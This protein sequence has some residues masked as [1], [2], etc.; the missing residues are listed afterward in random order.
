MLRV[1]ALPLY[2]VILVS[3]GRV[4]A[5]DMTNSNTVSI[6]GLS[7]IHRR[8]SGSRGTFGQVRG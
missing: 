4:G 3:K 2:I 6:A 1:K 5:S 8:T 7:R